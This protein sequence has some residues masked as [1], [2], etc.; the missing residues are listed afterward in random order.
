MKK[1]ALR[2]Y[3]PHASKGNYENHSQA[4]VLGD[5]ILIRNSSFKSSFRPSAKE[6]AGVIIGLLRVRQQAVSD[7]KREH[8]KIL[9]S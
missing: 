2:K 5:D 3:F 4:A 1:K 8:T 9:R 7:Q 6:K